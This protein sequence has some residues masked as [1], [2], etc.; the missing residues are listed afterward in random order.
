[1]LKTA[2][3]H[4]QDIR[5]SWPRYP[6][7]TAKM[8][9]AH[10]QDIRSSRAGCCLKLANKMSKSHG[11]TKPGLRLILSTLY[12]TIGD[13]QCH[14]LHDRPTSLPELLQRHLAR[15]SFPEHRSIFHRN[16]AV[17]PLSYT[18]SKP[19]IVSRDK[20]RRGCLQPCNI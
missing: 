10:G 12:V 1:M 19:S 14:L 4:G 16:V 9:K 13:T 18:V 7:P 20:S 5:S 8:S 17:N 6:N 2:E 11:S 15:N 3:A